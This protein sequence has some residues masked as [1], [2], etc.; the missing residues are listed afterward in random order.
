MQGQG[1]AVH[2]LVF[3][4][5]SYGSEDSAELF[6]G[7]SFALAEGELGV[8][9]AGADAGKT[10]LA[11]IVAGLIP[12]FTGGSLSGSLSFNGTDLSTLKPYQLM[13]DV[14]IVFQDSDEQI[15]TTRCDTEIAFALES[16]GIPTARLRDRVEAAIEL[17][18]LSAFRAR[19]PMTLSGGEKK[20][21]LL[22]C[23]SA[24]DPGLWI[25]DEAMEE[26]DEYW[27]SK[28]LAYLRSRRKT[29]FFLDSR[30][31][32]LFSVHD[33]R[34]TILRQGGGFH[35][36][37]K[38]ASAELEVKLREEGLALPHWSKTESADGKKTRTL[39]EVR[40]LAFR[41]PGEDSF[42]VRIPALSLQTGGVC[43]LV[44]RN[45]SGKSTLGRILCGLLTPHSGGVSIRDGRGE[46]PAAKETL[47]RMVGYMFQNPD[48]QIFLPTVF[49]ELALGLRSSGVKHAEIRGRV[50]AAISL[51]N[52]PSGQS[53][54]ALMSYG[55]RKRLQAATYHLLDRDLLIL[56][57]IDSG[58]S[59]GEFFPLLDALRS[60][61]AAI[62][63]VTHDIDLARAISRRILVMKEGKIRGDLVPSA[64]PML[65]AM[66]AEER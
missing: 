20:R 63:V 1:L 34:C 58:L 13:E 23:L 29:A 36:T 6:H 28:L 26:L 32:S 12:R 42:E 10:T 35:S 50:E 61:G 2:D 65:D 7:L 44:G 45:G 16:L 33:T 17:M 41:F 3:Q 60:G 25:L 31:S 40:D 64:F 49:E 56:D 22:A 43:A 66:L 27:K 54:P 30:W 4:Y 46:R 53:P 15:L 59:Y 47:Q 8:I 9:L 11:R 51:F 39:F 37:S 21:L 62:I 48:Y 14:G 24:I 55:A 19:N 18:G 57:E 52:L 38:G 5:P